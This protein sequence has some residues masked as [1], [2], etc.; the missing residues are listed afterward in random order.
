MDPEIYVNTLEILYLTE[1]A[2]ETKMIMV[3]FRDPVAE[4]QVEY[5]LMF[6]DQNGIAPYLYRRVMQILDA[7]TM[8]IVHV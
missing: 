8:Q 1:I 2:G 4:E 5:P 3:I 7:G 6:E